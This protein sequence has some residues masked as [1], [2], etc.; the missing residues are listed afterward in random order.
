MLLPHGRASSGFHSCLHGHR[1]T[2]SPAVSA[3]CGTAARSVR[4]DSG[5][6]ADES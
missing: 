2:G 5:F 4:P 1:Y 3:I 6:P